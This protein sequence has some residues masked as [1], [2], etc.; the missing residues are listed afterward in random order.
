[1]YVL[2]VFI[3]VC[4]TP[5]FPSPHNTP[6]HTHMHITTALSLSMETHEFGSAS[7]K[8]SGGS[9]GNEMICEGV[10]FMMCTTLSKH[11]V[12]QSFTTALSGQGSQ[13][14]GRSYSLS[15]SVSE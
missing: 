8:L 1:M 10:G 13:G 15:I 6:S 14:S 9:E 2:P 12:E 7:L 11:K 4:G 5:C 3:V